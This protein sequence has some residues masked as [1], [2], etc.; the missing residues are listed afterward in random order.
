V[1]CSVLQCVAECCSVLQCV[2]MCC[3]VLQCAAVCCS[4]LQCVAVCCSVLQ[5]VAVH[6]L[7]ILAHA[8]EDSYKTSSYKFS[9]VSSL[10]NLLYD[11]PIEQTFKNFYLFVIGGERQVIVREE[12]EG[13]DFVSWGLSSSIP[14]ISHTWMSRVT[15]MIESCQFSVFRTHVCAMTHSYTWHDSFVYETWFI[16]D[17]TRVQLL[18]LC[19]TTHSHVWHG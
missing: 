16:H 12:R 10:L 11:S 3:S 18:H 17:T 4:V 6:W 5:C 9:K 1:C 13:F 19:D 14:C 15:H 7:R 2:A 8:V